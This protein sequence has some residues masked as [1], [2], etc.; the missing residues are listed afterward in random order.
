MASLPRRRRRG[1]SPSHEHARRFGALASP[2]L[3]RVPVLVTGGNHEIGSSALRLHY[4]KKVTTPYRE[5]RTSPLA[6]SADVGPAHVVALNGYDNFVNDGDRLQ[7]KWLEGD[8]AGVD[9]S[10]PP[11]L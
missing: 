6:W 11:G 1:D 10:Q 4:L 5:A 3:S 7:R 9:G 2:L 8:L